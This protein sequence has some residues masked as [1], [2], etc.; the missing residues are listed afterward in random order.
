VYH[1]LVYPGG[2]VRMCD[3][4]KTLSTTNPDGCP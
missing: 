1:V 3:A 4:T 2:R